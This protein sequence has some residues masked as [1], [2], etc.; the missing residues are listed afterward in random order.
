M[1][2]PSALG[3]VF[4]AIVAEQFERLRDGDRF[5]YEAMYEG[6]ELAELKATRL[7]DVLVRN[8]DMTT[9]PIEVF[10]VPEAT[11]AAAAAAVGSALAALAR[12][13]R[14]RAI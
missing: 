4:T 11:T 1:A 13:R 2:A 9:L 14:R 8:T 5:W 10:S 12:A 7:R 6:S 3:E